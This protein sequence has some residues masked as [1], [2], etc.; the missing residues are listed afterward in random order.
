MNG[1][2]VVSSLTIIN[3]QSSDVGTY[4]CHAKN[5]IGSDRSSAVLTVNGKFI[6]QAL[7]LY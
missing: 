7:L 3:T 4:T 5:I 1:T 2:I 6:F